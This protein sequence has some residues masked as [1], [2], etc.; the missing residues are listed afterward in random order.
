MIP[1]VGGPGKPLDKDAAVNTAA[2][3]CHHGGL[4]APASVTVDAKGKR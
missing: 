2:P 4:W 3:L 1:E